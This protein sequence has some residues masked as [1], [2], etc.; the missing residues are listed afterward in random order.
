MNLLKA[1]V[2]LV[3]S[4]TAPA[5]AGPA[6]APAAPADASNA[7]TETRRRLEWN[8]GN[9]ATTV[10]IRGKRIRVEWRPGR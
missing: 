1:T 4:L 2:L 7:R 8:L 10:G 3:G 5:H 6:V 9:S